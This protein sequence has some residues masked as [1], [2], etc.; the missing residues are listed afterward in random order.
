MTTP[1]FLRDHA[2][3]LS[4]VALVVTWSSGF[5]GAELSSRAHAAPLTLLGWR[6]TVL[7]A[8]LVAVALARRTPWPTWRAWR[9]QIVLGVLCQVAYLLLVFEG[10]THG[11]P[12][13]TAALI[14]SLQPLLVATVAGALLGERSTPRTWVGML[15]GLVGVCVVVS[16]DLGIT[17]A[18]LWAYLLPTVGMLCLASG[19]VIGVRIRPPES[20]FQT[21]M[22]QSVVT[23]VVLMGLAAGFGQAAPPASVEFW[24]AVAWLIVLASLGG[25]LLYVFVA[26]RQGATVVSTLLFLTPPTTM[27][28]VYL[29]FGTQVT[30]AG[31]TGLAISGVGVWLALGGRRAPQ[32]DKTPQP[33]ESGLEPV[34]S[35]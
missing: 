34:R 23:A 24:R 7:A 28:W 20:L 17:G 4:S 35:T 22:M 6:F 10:V 27:F 5:V 26:E 3:A 11:V 1:R 16:G 19:T 29:M 8:L 15:L 14:A 33:G 31:L 12:G 13:G 18:P 2:G 21:M 30:I 9:R 25:Y 32:R